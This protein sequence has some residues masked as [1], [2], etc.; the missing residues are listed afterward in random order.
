VKL[1]R[2]AYPM[3]RAFVVIFVILFGFVG[4]AYAQSAK[5]AYK[6]LKKLEVR[7]QAGVSYRDY[8]AVLTDA[9][10]EVDLFLKS[11]AA[12]KNPQFSEHIK[13]AMTSYVM[14]MEVWKLKFGYGSPSD[15]IR[16]NTTEGK[17]ISKIYPK[18][19]IHRSEG[20]GSGTF[21][22]QPYQ[23]YFIPEVLSGLWSDASKE[24]NM[25]SNYLQ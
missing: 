6:A 4:L 25:A 15:I 11:K 22:I 2:E 18:A 14:A 21:R 19:K 23:Y 17:L 10:T 7:T 20:I 8:P 5:D 16:I 1:G 24:V 12:K 13:K 9:E 3:K